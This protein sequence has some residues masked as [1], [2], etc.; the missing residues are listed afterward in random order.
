MQLFIKHCLKNCLL[1]K[2]MN[3]ELML[4]L[5]SIGFRTCLE[6]NLNIYFVIF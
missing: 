1:R 5:L 3:S 6:Q 2:C 4:L